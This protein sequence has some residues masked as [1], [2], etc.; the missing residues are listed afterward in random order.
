LVHVLSMVPAQ[1][2]V[3]RRMSGLKSIFLVLLR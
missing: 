1:A 3:V 2:A